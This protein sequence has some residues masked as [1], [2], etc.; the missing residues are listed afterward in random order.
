ME[1]FGWY[2]S[3]YANK[4]AIGAPGTPNGDSSVMGSVFVYASDASAPSSW[5]ELSRLYTH[6][7]ESTERFGYSV[8]LHEDLLL[9]GVVGGDSSTSSGSAML[10]SLSA[11]EDGSVLVQK[12]VTLRPFSKEISDSRTAKAK[13]FG[14]CVHLYG[15]VHNFFCGL[16]QAIFVSSLSLIE[17]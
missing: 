13:G 11:V 7:G 17:A 3:A 14:T 2:V 6:V 8:S 12:E 16:F 15:S 9:I 1:Y 10:Y 4:V 5:T